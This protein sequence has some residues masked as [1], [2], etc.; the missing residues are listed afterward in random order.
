MKAIKSIGFILFLSFALSHCTKQDDDCDPNKFCDTIV[1]D[2]GDVNIKVTYNGNGIPIIVY[3]GYAD[4]NDIL[5]YD[6]LW[7]EE[8]SYYL[9][10]GNRYAVEAYYY[11]SNSTIIALDGNKLKESSFW[12]CDEECYELAEITL[13]VKKL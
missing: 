7:S 5:F 9:P 13:D 1:Q 8:I 4:Q 11:E 6:T 3:K 2:S 10:L 12:N